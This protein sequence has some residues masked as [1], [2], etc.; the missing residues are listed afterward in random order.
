[1]SPFF[2][3]SFAGLPPLFLCLSLAL[4]S[5]SVDMTI[6][7]SLKL[8]LTR[9][10]KKFIFPLSSLVV[11]TLQDAGGYAISRKNN[12][13]LHL[14]CHTCWLSY[15][16]LVCL[17]CGRSV[18]RAVYCH[19]I[20]KFFRMGRFTYKTKEARLIFTVGKIYIFLPIFRKARPSFFRVLHIMKSAI[21]QGLSNTRLLRAL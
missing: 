12:F 14:G 1:M 10:Q 20:T 15:F 16:T 21:F 9:I 19:V 18:A 11:S 5:K 7:L 6:N 13:E 4:Y 3:L 8:L 17:W 2:W